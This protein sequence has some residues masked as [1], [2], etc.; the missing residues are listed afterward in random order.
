MTL[1]GLGVLTLLLAASGS[2]APARAQPAERAEA[3]LPG[4]VDAMP[5]GPSVAERLAEIQRLVQEA[6]V[7]PPIARQRRV[8]GETS[9]AFRVGSGGS[10]EGV[11]VARTSGHLE[12]DR[13]ATRAVREADGLP[14]VYGRLEIPVRFDLLPTR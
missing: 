13:A 8:E 7:Y 10:A 3:A 1:L 9:V 4:V 14:H 5:V 11:E 6:L 2:G 12:L